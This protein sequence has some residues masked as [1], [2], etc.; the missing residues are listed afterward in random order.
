[1]KLIFLSFFL[2]I[3]S[4][5]ECDSALEKDNKESAVQEQ[6]R[7]NR[8][9]K[10][11]SENPWK[12]LI[13]FSVMGFAAG[14]IKGRYFTNREAVLSNPNSTHIKNNVLPGVVANKN[15]SLKNY[16]AIQSN[17]QKVVKDNIKNNFNNSIEDKRY[18]KINRLPDNWKEYYPLIYFLNPTFR[19]HF[20]YWNTAKLLEDVSKEDY[21]KIFNMINSGRVTNVHNLFEE[22][23]LNNIR[24]MVSFTFADN[25]NKIRD[26]V[27]YKVLDFDYFNDLNRFKD[28]QGKDTTF[29]EKLNTFIQETEDIR[30]ELRNF[31]K[32]VEKDIGKQ[33]EPRTFLSK[34]AVKNMRINREVGEKLKEIEERYS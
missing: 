23:N 15:Q 20:V 29:I 22:M 12:F 24:R 3:L 14:L 13:S 6:S 2:F 33:P 7:F 17:D 34:S 21:K 28:T 19:E 1:M 5:I 30:R 10:W 11:M 9:V 26:K 25:I 27:M 8:F 18:E 4:D 16:N 32:K 31:I